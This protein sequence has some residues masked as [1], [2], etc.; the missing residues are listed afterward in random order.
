MVLVTSW[1]CLGVLNLSTKV[2]LGLGF[3]YYLLGSV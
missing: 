2:Y 3:S 1:S